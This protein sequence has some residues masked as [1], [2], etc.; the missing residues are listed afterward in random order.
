MTRILPHP[1]LFA[2]LTVM[3]MMLTRFSLGHLLLGAAVAYGASLSMAALLPARMRFRRWDL[4]PKVLALIAWDI[5][6]SNIAVAWAILSRHPRQPGFVEIPL[7]LRD[8]NGL[9]LLAIVLTA[10]PGTAWIEYR[11]KT[12]TLLIHAFDI[13][14]EAHWRDLIK[15]RYEAIMMEIFE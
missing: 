9:A 11:A 5:V 13:G 7:D 14:E 15:N 6:R 10:T 8:R 2:A 4:L 12:G 1:V 3:W